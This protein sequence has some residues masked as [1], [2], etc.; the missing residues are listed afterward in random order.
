MSNKRATTV[1][2]RPGGKKPKIDA[3]KHWHTI[4]AASETIKRIIKDAGGKRH[5]D[6]VDSAAVKEIVMQVSDDE[7]IQD[8]LA[9]A[10]AQSVTQCIEKFVKQAKGVPSL[11]VVRIS[12]E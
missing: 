11:E 8:L 2:A 9:K 1:E 6:H 5:V 7:V 12:R 10:I 4:I 3:P